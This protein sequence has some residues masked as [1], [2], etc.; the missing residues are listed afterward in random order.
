MNAWS[1]AYAPGVE[2]VTLKGEVAPRHFGNRG[3]ADALAAW[4]RWH[5]PASA[6]GFNRDVWVWYALLERARVEILASRDLPG[7]AHNLRHPLLLAPQEP[8]MARLYLAAR[9]ILADLPNP[10]EIL[11]Q[12]ESPSRVATFLRSLHAQVLRRSAAPAGGERT[13]TLRDNDVRRALL[14]AR[15]SLGHGAQFAAAVRPLAEQLAR[16]YQR[17]SEEPAASQIVIDTAEAD[18]D[19]ATPLEDASAQIERPGEGD[20]DVPVIR[21]FPGYAVF[22]SA[23]DEVDSASRWLH[24]DDALALRSLSDL[25]RRRVRQLAQRLQRRLQAAQLRQWTF[26]HEEGRLDNRR[27][28][29]LVGERSSRR[30]YR[31][32]QASPVP[33]ACVTLL[34]DQSGSMRGER[35]RMAALAIDLAAHTLEVCGVQCEILGF[36][37]RYSADN[38]VIK[39]WRKAGSP[40]MP[41]RLNAVR[42]IIFKTPKQPW[43]RARPQLGLLLREGFG[44]ENVDG[45]ALHWAASRLVKRPEPRK[46]LVVLS[47]G[48]P[49]DEATAHANGR[50]FLEQHLRDVIHELESSPIQLVAIGT[51]QEVGRY[52]QQALTVRRPEAVAEVLFERLGELLTRTPDERGKRKR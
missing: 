26:E 2:R 12:P 50:A 47:D 9:A 35:Q 42:H 34:V 38:P 39:S 4:R 27:L 48:A 21:A 3:H 32:E 14:A 30:V 25:D 45:E 20:A 17:A 46:I 1:R 28:A 22:S 13:A 24:P 29:R 44:F 10:S 8:A 6:A 11:L 33:E 18:A 52:Y 40:A 16:H 41:G 23:L 15:D 43:R 5:D 49:F 31:V 36:T 37:T 19:E 51:G 7:I